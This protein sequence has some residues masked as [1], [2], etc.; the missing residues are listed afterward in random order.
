MDIPLGGSSCPLFP[1]RIEIWNVGF[2][3]GGS[4]ED[5]EKNPRNKDANQP[6][7]QPTC[8]AR[9]GNGTRATGWEACALT[10][11]LSLLP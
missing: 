9:S 2:A 7:T 3:E 11:A 5:P 8:D 6:Q 4:T 10:I 1:D